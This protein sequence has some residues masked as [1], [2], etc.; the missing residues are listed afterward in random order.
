[1]LKIAQSRQKISANQHC[2]VWTL[3]VEDIVYL[4]DDPTKG[5]RRFG[6]KGI[7]SPRYVGPFKILSRNGEVAY[8]LELQVT[9]YFMCHDLEDI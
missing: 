8:K 6:V 9:T 2:R 1:M 3:K 4:R 7:L 5:I